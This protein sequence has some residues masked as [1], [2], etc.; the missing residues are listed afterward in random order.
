MSK[1]IDF[2]NSEEFLK[3]RN[4]MYS[5]IQEQ[6][7]QPTLQQIMGYDLAN[8][9]FNSEYDKLQQKHKDKFNEFVI[10]SLSDTKMFLFLTEEPIEE[11]TKFC[12][13]YKQLKL[14]FNTKSDE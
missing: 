7:K 5:Y 6:L 14:N 3:V 1:T 10:K 11:I 12:S 2:T 9:C 8:F 4:R 13:D